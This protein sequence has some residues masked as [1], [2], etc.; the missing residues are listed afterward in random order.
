MLTDE[1]RR[2]LLRIQDRL[3]W[4][5]TYTIHYANARRKNSSPERVGGHQSSST[6]VLTLLTALYFKLLRPGDRIAVKPTAAPIF[7]AIQV[8]RGLLPPDG[9]RAYRALGGLQA[10]PSRAKNPDWFDF[11]TGSMGLGAVAP[12]FAALMDRYLADH[13]GGPG[14]V[15]QG[16]PAVAGRTRNIALVGDAELDEGSVWEAWTEEAMADLAGHIVVVDLNRQSLDRVVGDRRSRQLDALFRALGWHVVGLRFG[17]RLEAAFAGAGGPWLRARLEAM[18]NLEYH[19]LLRLP[20]PAARTALLAGAPA[21]SRA[22]LDA[23]LGPDVHALLED[24]GG[25][26][27]DAIVA[28]FDEADRVPDRPVAI[29]A[30]TLKGWRLPFAGDPLNHGAQLT[31]DQVQAM[32]RELGVAEGEEFL[33]FPP[34]SEEARYIERVTAAGVGLPRRYI[35]PAPVPV[36]ERLELPPRPATSTQETFGDALAALG[37]DATIAP[38]LVTVS[39]DVATTTHLSGWVNRRGVYAVR[40][41]DD[42]F[43]RHGLT[44]LV[45]WRESG[46]GQ[47]LELGI[48]EASFFVLLSVLGLAPELT[49][50]TL[51]PIGTLYDCF[52]PRGL[53]PL[54]HATYS[55]ARF[56]LVASPSGITLAPEGGAHQSVLTPSFGIEVPNIAA[57]EPAFAREVAWLLLEA[58][59]QIQDPHGP[60]VYLRLSTKVVD[61]ALLEP[62]IERLGEATLR[63]Q[64]LAGGY[65]LIDQRDRADYEPGA[66]VVNVAAVGAMVPEAVAASRVLEA[67]G[68]F[69]NVLV[70]TSPRR[71]YEGWRQ[72]VDPRARSAGAGARAWVRALVPPDEVEGQAPVITV[73]DGHS[74][75]L[76]WLGAAVGVPQ[77]P[78]GVDA[79]GQSG[80]RDD[81]YQHYG[82]G[83]EAIATAARQALG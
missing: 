7:Y 21:E 15:A 83:A 12:G 40:P 38:H 45:R 9:L 39:P 13:A 2:L 34:G 80:A 30:W 46:A 48:G 32:Q 47:H 18:D 54:L 60:A 77:V 79:F 59:R 50:R 8:L 14:P 73:L 71:C 82:I 44:S 25:H 69:A 4:L 6:S 62:V 36:P 43:E 37:R 72:S 5:A 52:L 65:R 56:I 75:A 81:L 1:E 28:A 63:R 58:L 29:L 24:L 17:R 19:A 74:H 3:L 42:A 64:V 57:Y 35:R 27:L 49:G 23:R 78:L 51:L 41:R 67:E 11:S 76:A 68:V 31:A 16:S 55:K 10:Y 70:L 20:A 66:N 22:A 61:Q 33:P 26:D 53:D